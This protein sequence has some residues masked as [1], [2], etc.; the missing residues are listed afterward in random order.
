MKPG[1]QLKYTVDFLNFFPDRR[2]II[3]AKLVLITWFFT[4]LCVGSACIY[5]MLQTEAVRAHLAAARLDEQHLEKKIKSRVKIIQHYLGGVNIH[6][7]LNDSHLK[8]Y[9]KFDQ[10]FDQLA[11]S[12]VPGVWLTA[13]SFDLQKNRYRIEGNALSGKGVHEIQK[14]WASL[15]A[16]RHIDLKAMKTTYVNKKSKFKKQRRR[17]NLQRPVAPSY[18]Q[19]ILQNEK[20][21]SPK[22]KSGK[23]AG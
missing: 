13:L 5:F 20:F 9:L 8:Q 18:Y 4:I 23:R 11:S 22:R 7:A 12:P 19:F 17:K 21:K 2:I 14:K 10:V 16:T 3:S 6:R 1:R 15:L